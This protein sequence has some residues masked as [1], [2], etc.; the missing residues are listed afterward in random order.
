MKT[1]LGILLLLSALPIFGQEV[2]F[3]S[4]DPFNGKPMLLGLCTREAFKDTSFSWWFD[5]EYKM[6]EVDS[7]S[8]AKIS[9]KIKNTDITIVMGTWC[10]DSRT[11]VPEFYKILDYLNYPSDKVKLINIDRDKKGRDDEIAGLNIHLV[12]TFIFYHNGK[13]V[14]RIVESPAETLEKDLEIILNKE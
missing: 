9:A 4:K 7:T 6:Y 1:Y 14:G 13:E 3:I 8:L 2:N 11:L 10:S 5:S 12:P